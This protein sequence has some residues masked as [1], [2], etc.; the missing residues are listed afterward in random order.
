MHTEVRHS[1][2]EILMSIAQMWESRQ[3]EVMQLAQRKAGQVSLCCMRLLQTP[4]AHDGVE[5]R[6]FTR[7]IQLQTQSERERQEVFCNG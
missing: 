5:L 4:A 1:E 6:K 3:R 2:D 7:T